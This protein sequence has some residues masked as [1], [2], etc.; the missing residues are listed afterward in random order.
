MTTL[1]HMLVRN[2]LTLFSL[3][4]YLALISFHFLEQDYLHWFG[5]GGYGHVLP[6]AGVLLIGFAMYTLAGT[7]D[8]YTLT[9][10]HFTHPERDEE[11]FKKKIDKW[12][13]YRVGYR[14]ALEELIRRA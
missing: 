13:C 3:L 8:G 5:K 14:T 11:A 2:P 4:T 1:L 12:Y 10:K 9:M 6:L 7:L